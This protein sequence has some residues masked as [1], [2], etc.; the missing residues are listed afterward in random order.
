LTGSTGVARSKIE[1]G[2]S[3]DSLLLIIELFDRAV[4]AGEGAGAIRAVTVEALVSATAGSNVAILKPEDADDL[5]GV[6]VYTVDHLE[7]IATGELSAQR[8]TMHR[9]GQMRK[10]PQVSDGPFDVGQHPVSYVGIDAAI[11]IGDRP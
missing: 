2:T 3:I 9:L 8:P 11:I 1:T 6:A 10:L 4:E 7:T 5:D